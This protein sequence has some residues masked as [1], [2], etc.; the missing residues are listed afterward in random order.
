MQTSRID[1]YDLDAIPW[2]RPLGELE[3]AMAETHT[4]EEAPEGLT[5]WLATT[6]PDGRPHVTAVGAMWLDG[7]YYFTSGD[8]TR[9]SRNLAEDDRCVVSVSLPS[10]DLVVEG[11]ATKVT[12]EPTLQRLADLY[13]RQGW[14]PTVKDGAFTHEYSAPSAGPPPWFLYAVTPKV[15]F[16]V[17]TKEPFGA[18]RWRFDT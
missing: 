10:I 13:A 5:H 14:A 15:A 18:T 16:G 9:K 12:D 6:C 3:A 2:S 11:M 4:P 1:I 17:A 8:G 7:R